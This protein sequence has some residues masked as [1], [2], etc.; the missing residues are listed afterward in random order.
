MKEFNDVND[1]LDGVADGKDHD[2]D[3]EDCCNIYIPP[4]SG[5]GMWNNQPLPLDLANN[6]SIDEDEDKEGDHID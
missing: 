4:Q 1:S 6:Y 3:D 2:D 5:G